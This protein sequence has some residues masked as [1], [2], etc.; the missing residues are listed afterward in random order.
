M[1]RYVPDIE[2][3]RDESRYWLVSLDARVVG[4]FAMLADALALAAILECSPRAR[5][6]AL[7]GIW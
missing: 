6:E 7:D 3:M 4:R 5:A 1:A 2:V